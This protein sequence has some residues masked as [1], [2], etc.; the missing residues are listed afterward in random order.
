MHISIKSLALLSFIKNMTTKS[1]KNIM[2]MLVVMEN[3]LSV[4]KK[5]LLAQL[6]SSLKIPKQ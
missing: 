6:L 5:L 1:I 2:R 4:L 3:K